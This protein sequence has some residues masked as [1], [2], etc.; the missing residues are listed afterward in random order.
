[1]HTPATKRE[2][3][4]WKAETMNRSNKWIAWGATLLMVLLVCD[5][6]SAQNTRRRVRRPR[7]PSFS[8]QPALS[9]YLALVNPNMDVGLSYAAI[10]AP[11]IDQQDLNQRNARAIYDL[12]R[13]ADARDTGPYGS[14]GG[15]GA[16]GHRSSYQ[17]YS[18][19]YGGG[20]GGAASSG[21][22]RRS[23]GGGGGGGG[24]YGGG[25]GGMGMF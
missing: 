18:H 5:A 14:T 23:K 17:N 24:G 16:T 11:L 19:Y 3:S 22:S 9:P 4:T 1:M 25:M 2:N 6:A 10:A 13:D 20:G 12:Q 7:R 8:D 15:L 21:F